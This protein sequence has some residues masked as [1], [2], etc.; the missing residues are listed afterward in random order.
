M[1]SVQL[2]RRRDTMGAI[3]LRPLRHA[4]MMLGSVGFRVGLDEVRRKQIETQRQA[5]A[6]DVVETHEPE[7]APRQRRSVAGG[8]PDG[9]AQAAGRLNAVAL[10]PVQLLVVGFDRPNFSGEGA[11]RA[12]AAALERRR[13]R[14]RPAGRSQERG[15]CRR[16]PA[17]LRPHRRRGRRRCGGRADRAR[18]RGQRGRRWW[19]ARGRVLVARRGHPEQLRR[20]SRARRAPLGDRHA[21]RDPRCARLPVVDA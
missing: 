6:R 13:A 11:R 9:E 10:K 17:P 16:A 3:L 18:R 7:G 15:G 2:R 1:E 12:G 19:P 8:V 20:H 14:H 21:R 5:P 4:P